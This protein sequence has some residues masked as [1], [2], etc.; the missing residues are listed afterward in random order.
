MSREP[1]KIKK[2]ATELEKDKLPE[3][4]KFLMKFYT[5][6]GFIAP[7]NSGKTNTI[8]NLLNRR[9]FYRNKF[10]KIVVISSTFL[11]DP[12]WK[13]AKGI[14]EAYESYD[15]GIITNLIEEQKASLQ[16]EGR[17]ETPRVLLILDDVI[18]QI[19]KNKSALNSLSMRL[20]HYKVTCWIATQKFNRLPVAFRTQIQYWVLFKTATKNA[21]ER[22]SIAREVGAFTSEDTF[23]RLWDAVGENTWN[24]MVV[25]IRSP[26]S[27]MFRREFQAYLK[28]S[29]YFADEK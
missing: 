4:D 7:T 18:D 27:K 6:T 25:H 12:M 26:E 15:D 8:V 11:I 22:E 9:A 2:V 29:D 28:A 23:L 14:D 1:Y 13:K 3:L 5:I 17:D 21:L 16:N 20:R 24:F 10:D 19:P